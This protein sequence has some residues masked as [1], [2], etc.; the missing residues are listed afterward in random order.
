MNSNRGHV[1]AHDRPCIP[2]ALIERAIEE[3]PAA[4][5]AEYLAEF[6][7]DVS[8]FLASEAV[9]A[10]I[11]AG[12]HELPPISGATY[13]AFCD[14]SGGSQD[15][16]TLAVAHAEGTGDA[17]R[18]VLDMVREVRPPFSPDGVAKDFADALK[19]YGVRTVR[20]DRYGGAWPAERFKVHGIDYKPAKL[21]KS[22]LYREV[23]SA[24]NAARVELLDL[25][26]LRAQFLG[27]ERRVARGGRDSLDHGPG[28]H[29]D[30][31][32]A[33]AG[34]IHAVGEGARNT[35]TV[36]EVVW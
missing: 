2:E 14:P 8:A 26:R 34:A 19:H 23:L 1:D 7:R 17:R 30:V 15:S 10:C 33:A 20:G 9:D 5:A 31:A 13:R 18:T 21:A 12:R 24:L 4:A 29:D 27:L 11:V 28:G 3:D 22:D 25:P 36:C 32:N 6:R 16:M 35:V